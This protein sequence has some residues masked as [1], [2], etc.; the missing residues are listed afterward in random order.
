MKRRALLIGIDHYQMLSH[1]KYARRDVETFAA[2]L[3]QM[4]GF[5]ADDIT[6][7]TCQGKSALLADAIYI[8]HALANLQK[9]VDLDLLVIGFWGHGFATDQGS[10]FLCGVQTMEQDLQRTALSLDLVKAKIGQIQA[11]DTLVLLD[12]CQSRPAVAGRNAIADVLGQDE[13]ASF[14]ALARDIKATR[15]SRKDQREPRVALLS[16]CRA[17]QKA[18]EWEERKHGIFTAHL[19]DG[20]QDGLSSLTQLSEYVSQRVTNTTRQQHQQDQSPFIELIGGDIA[21]IS[22]SANDLSPF[23]KV[24]KTVG[25]QSQ[26]RLLATLELDLNNYRASTASYGEDQLKEFLNRLVPT[27]LTD[28]QTAADQLLPE[29]LF[30]LGLCA[31]VGVGLAQ[32]KFAAYRFFSRG[33]KAQDVLCQF[34]LGG[35]YYSGVGVTQDYDVAVKWYELAADQGLAYA[36]SKL[37]LCYYLGQSV[38]QD[39]AEAV[40]WYRL[41]TQKQDALAQLLL[42]VCFYNGEGVSQDHAKAVKWYRLAAEQEEPNAQCQLGNCY[43]KGEGITQDH[44]EAVKW[45]R[46]AALHGIDEAQCRLGVCYCNGEGVSQDHTEGVE[47][48]RLAAEQKNSNARYNLGCCCE[49]GLGVAHNHVEAVKWYRLAAEQGHASAQYNLGF[50]YET[51]KGVE[52]NLELAK[53]NYSEALQAGHSNAQEGVS[54][55]LKLLKKEKSVFKKIFG[56]G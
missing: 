42:G 20:L 47:W 48:L 41:A 10:R 3:Q 7:M 17:G 13:E 21:L 28:W 27:R 54:R 46:L 49:Y 15:Q 52:K 18:Y 9:E 19:I 51:G 44:A 38:G 2:V 53:K 34:K 25:K 45:Y 55:I 5:A 31:S 39:H 6:L 22:T 1:L 33:A 26:R 40:K 36:Q 56:G 14:G 24:M 43:Y 32:D 23:P 50:C 16:S 29:G 12:C 11:K 35:C 8:E 37:G 4:C 30:F